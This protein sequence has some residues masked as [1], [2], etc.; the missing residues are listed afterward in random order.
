MITP[1]NFIFTIHEG[2]RVDCCIYVVGAMYFNCLYPLALMK[3]Y[4]EEK[5]M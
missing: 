3:V 1:K 4:L 2:I 5:E